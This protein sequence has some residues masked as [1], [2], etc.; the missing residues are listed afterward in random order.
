MAKSDD[1][2]LQRFWRKQ[3]QKQRQEGAAPGEE[4]PPAG[5]PPKPIH[6]GDKPRRNDPCPCGSGKKYKHCCGRAG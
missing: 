5:E 1:R 4:P 3:E 6:A 2:F